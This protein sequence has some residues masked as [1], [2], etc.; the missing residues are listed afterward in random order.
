MTVKKK[1]THVGPTIETPWKWVP[2]EFCKL[3]RWLE[4]LH[5]D[6]RVNEVWMVPHGGEWVQVI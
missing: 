4:E 2:L 6:T 3:I 5:L 1:T